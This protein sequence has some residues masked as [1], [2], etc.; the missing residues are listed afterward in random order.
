MIMALVLIGVCLGLLLRQELDHF[1][2]VLN[3]L[4]Q[5][6]TKEPSDTEI[7]PRTSSRGSAHH[8]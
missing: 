6:W 7:I 1:F 2:Q 3:P 4:G 8:V 5:P